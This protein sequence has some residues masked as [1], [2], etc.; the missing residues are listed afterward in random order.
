[1]ICMIVDTSMHYL[2]IGLYKDDVCLENYTVDGNRRQSEECLIQ[3]EVVLK[4]HCLSLKDLD[5][6]IVTVGPGSYTGVRI[7]LTT[8]KILAVSLNTPIK[9]ISSL[10]AMVGLN[11]G[12][13]I[14]DARSKKIFVGVYNEGIDCIEEQLMDIDDF[15]MFYDSYNDYSLYG[16]V[17]LVGLTSSKFILID[18]IYQL[19]K[20][21]VA[22]KEIDHL[23]PVY[24]KEVEAKKIC[25]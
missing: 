21:V 11:K 23:V 2:A 16:D 9:V 20:H 8:A 1:M 15:N 24:L 7:A 12:I 14:L 3:M 10:K 25:L 19:S 18:H 5:E 4:K 17:H 6:F 22:C 13:A